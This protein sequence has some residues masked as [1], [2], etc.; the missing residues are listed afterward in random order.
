MNQRRIA[1]IPRQL[2]V[3]DLFRIVGCVGLA[4]LAGTPLLVGAEPKIER[5]IPP[6]GAELPAAEYAKLRER[7]A[8]LQPALA[9]IS[10]HA[11]APDVLIFAKAV[12]FALRHNEFYSP[13]DFEVARQAL[14]E[15]ERRLDSIRSNRTPW[16]RRHGLVVRGFRSSIDDSLQPYGLWISDDLDFDR[17]A[18]LYVWL[19][20]RGDRVTDL[21]FLHR[22]MHRDGTVTPPGS[23][24]LHP[25]G[26]HCLGYK[27][28]GET[29]V[30]EAI[31]HVASQYHIDRDRIALMGFSMGG[32]GAWHLG[33]HYADKWVA[34]SPGAGFAETARYNRLEPADYPP[35][36]EQA[37]WGIYDVPNYVRNLF[38]VP[39]V[40]YS[41]ENDKQIQAARV[42]EAAFHNEGR[43][44]THLVGPGMG[45]KYHPDTLSEIVRRVGQAVEKGRR[46]TPA[47]IS[48]QTRT[49]RY[50]RFAWLEIRGLG[51]HWQDARVDAEIVRD[52]QLRLSTRNVTALRL[53]PWPD[54]R[55]TVIEIDGERIVVANSASPLST[56]ELHLAAGWR[57]GPPAA[58][59]SRKSPGLQ[60]PIDDAF[61]EPFLVVAPSGI[62]SSPEVQ[63]WVDFELTHT[64]DRWRALYRGEVR[65]KQDSEVSEQDLQRYHLVAWGDPQSNLVLRRVFSEHGSR[66]LP[67]QWTPT[68]LQVGQ[69]R[70]SSATHV[71]VLIYP[72]PLNPQK[73]LVVN[74]GP[75]FREAHDRT[76]S[77]Q[78]PKLPDWAIVDIR[79]PPDDRSPGRIVAADFFSETWQLRH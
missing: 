70:F 34:I 31:E 24:V 30:L 67:L 35:S 62:A 51:A 69:R 38:N 2:G 12:S 29:D 65:I 52:K 10:D 45:H 14:D 13:E 11:Q 60:G 19:H 63:E 41:G 15:A 23:I 26:R 77:L 33:A 74:S 58:T 39:V 71:P 25:F 49:L 16:R 53:S 4:L 1:P 48:L 68:Q 43:E 18:P 76:N 72:N 66:A 59:A 36:Y 21:H 5:R 57:E 22:R 61:C 47:K 79:Q 20:G 42:M 55:N 32:A 28:A 46:R 9:I 50:H 78:N 54:M 8:A 6:P 40:A 75:T 44:L 17:P 56:A 7:I 3:I 64:R 37:L 27:S 73:Y